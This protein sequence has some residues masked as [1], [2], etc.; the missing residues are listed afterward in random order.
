MTALTQEESL[1]QKLEEKRILVTGGAGFIGS[2]AVKQ[3]SGTGALV[4]VLDNF[5]SGKPSYVPAVHNVKI[6]EGD[7]CDR[8]MVEQVVRDQEIVIHLAALPFIPDSYYF[9][10]EFF[11]VNTM[12]TLNMLQASIRSETVMRFIQV[13]S[14]EVYGTAKYVPM[15]ENHPTFPHSTYAV[16]KLAADRL[17]FTI[18][19]EHNFPVVIIRPFNCYGPNITQPYIVPEITVQLLKKD[20]LVLGKMESS[21][22]FTY[23]E[24]TAR[25]III[26]SVSDGLIGET[27][28]LGSGKDIKIKDL[29]YFIASIMGKRIEITLDGSR[30]RPY[31]VER[32]VCDWSKAKKLLG[33]QPKVS[34]KDGFRRT[35]NWLIANTEIVQKWVPYKE[36]YQKKV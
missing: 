5:S 32:L 35:I 31:D 2:H 36:K 20:S 25:G 1:L 29:A 15:D 34:L 17:A 19:K 26:A 8:K 12:G 27:I 9:P 23:V 33:W 22:D 28:N 6:V 7:I 16:S 11:R 30:L 24:D 10:D 18:H 21:R 4:T 13:S 3:L 14:S